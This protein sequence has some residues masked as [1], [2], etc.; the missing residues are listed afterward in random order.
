MQRAQL[1][2]SLT[3]HHAEALLARDPAAL[4][5]LRRI[6]SAAG[7]NLPSLP[8]PETRAPSHVIIEEL[9]STEPSPVQEFGAEPAGPIATVYI[10]HGGGSGAGNPAAG[11]LGPMAAGNSSPAYV[12]SPML[13]KRKV[14][15]DAAN[16]DVHATSF[17]KRL[18]QDASVANPSDVASADPMDME[19]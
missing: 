18:R 13:G 1:I 19:D 16:A 4:E 5:A 15:Y 7:S 14:G 12:Q 10:A 9:L 3:R 8:E 17:P 11:S 6:L 2:E